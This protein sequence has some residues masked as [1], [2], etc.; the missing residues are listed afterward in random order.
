MRVELVLRRSDEC[1]NNFVSYVF[2]IV[3]SA[4]E[5]ALTI[6]YQDPKSLQTPQCSSVQVNDC[7]FLMHVCGS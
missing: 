6:R 1:Y 4:C 3:A 2:Q 7:E 5:I